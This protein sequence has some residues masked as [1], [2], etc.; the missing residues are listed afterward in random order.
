MPVP[1]PSKTPPPP[2]PLVSMVTTDS[3]TL[4]RMAWMSITPS[5]VTIAGRATSGASSPSTART[6][7]VVPPTS[8][9][10]ATAPTTTPSHAP[11]PGPS[12]R[13]GRTGPPG[14]AAAEPVAARVRRSAVVQVEEAAGAP[15][16][17]CSPEPAAGPAGG[18]GGAGRGADRRALVR[19]RS[20]QP[21]SSAPMVTISPPSNEA[22]AAV[23]P[24]CI[25]G[26]RKK[27][28]RTGFP[29]VERSSSATE[30]R[31]VPSGWPEA[32]APSS[33]RRCSFRA[34]AWVWRSR[35]GSV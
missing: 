21:R 16:G 13:A 28:N 30:D 27:G 35:G 2:L 26:F 18:T 14:G 22:G 8:R 7:A 23:I 19:R 20:G 17:R 31:W 11:A 33:R 1:A 34:T 12:S 5:G 4:S 3:W 10:P 32:P 15:T 9:P 29:T 24:R 25:P 6:T